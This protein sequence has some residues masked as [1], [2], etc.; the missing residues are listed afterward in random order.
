MNWLLQ[1]GYAVVA[2]DGP[3]EYTVITESRAG[4][5]GIGV[6]VTPGTVAYVTTGGRFV[7][8][9]FSF[10]FIG[11]MIYFFSISFLACFVKFRC[12]TVHVPRS[13][14]TPKGKEIGVKKMK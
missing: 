8:C 14:Q 13:S 3:G 4:N 5:D 1:D 9:I 12:V 10:F 11:A 6:R 2:S 7:C